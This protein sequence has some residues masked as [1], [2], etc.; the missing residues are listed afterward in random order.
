[1]I[2]YLDLIVR[3]ALLYLLTVTGHLASLDGRKWLSYFILPLW[4]LYFRLSVLRIF[5]LEIGAVRHLSPTEYRY[6][7]DFLQNGW[8]SL[9]IDVLFLAVVIKLYRYFYKRGEFT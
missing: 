5:S 8:I 9:I 1:M 6:W 7:L 2:I 3:F 4:L